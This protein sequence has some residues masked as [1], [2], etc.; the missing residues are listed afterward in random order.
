MLKRPV[1]SHPAYSVI[2]KTRTLIWED[3]L[4]SHKKPTAIYDPRSRPRFTSVSGPRS[5]SN[6]DYREMSSGSKAKYHLLPAWLE[7]GL[8]QHY[9]EL[10]FLKLQGFDHIYLVGAGVG[11]WSGINN[12]IKYVE[13]EHEEFPGRI[14]PARFLRLTDFPEAKLR[15]IFREM[16][17]DHR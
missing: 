16:K 10:I 17:N 11:K 1:P 7:P 3:G 4:D 13:L 12:F 15:E 14:Y 5:T 2:G 8:D 9:C 6:Y